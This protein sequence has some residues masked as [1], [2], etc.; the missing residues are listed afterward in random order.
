MELLFLLFCRNN[1]DFSIPDF[2]YYSSI[3]LSAL[4]ATFSARTKY[5]SVI[6][7]VH[8]FCEHYDLP[9]A[10]YGNVPE[11]DSQIPVSHLLDLLQGVTPAEKRLQGNEGLLKLTFSQKRGNS[12]ARSSRRLKLQFLRRRKQNCANLVWRQ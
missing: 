1:L 4:D 11:V 6:D 7:V 9:F 3:G 2:Q 12:N 10:L 5:S 8:R